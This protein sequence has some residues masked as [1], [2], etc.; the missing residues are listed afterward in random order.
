MLS[1]KQTSL[2]WKTWAAI[3]AEQGWAHRPA[4]EK[5]SL[6]HELH[7]RL[8]LPESM[9]AWSNKHFS[10][11][12]SES[13]ALRNTID[14]RDRDKENVVWMVTRLREA[15]VLVLGHDY[16]RTIMI[17]F[18]DSVDPDDFPME[19]AN[20]RDLINLR[21]TLN[22]RLGR[23]IQR[24]R[25]GVLVPAPTC[26]DFFDRSQADIISCLINKEPITPKPSRRRYTLPAQPKTFASVQANKDLQPF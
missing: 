20:Q 9:R 3:C 4:K 17:D 24:I 10:R 13:A 7:I 15:F 25:D 26:P 12:L 18:G 11:F 8:R 2:Y 21:A 5:D 14:I 19:S 16:A 6:R 23:V 1:P 22:N